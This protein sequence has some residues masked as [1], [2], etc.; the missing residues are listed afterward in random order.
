MDYTHAARRRPAV[1][2]GGH[3]QHALPVEPAGHQGLRRGRRHRGARGRH[4]RHHRCAGPRGHRH[5]GNA[6]GGL[7]A[8]PRRRRPRWP[9]N[10]GGDP[11][12]RSSITARSPW[13][14]PPSCWRPSGEAKLLAG[15]HT[16]LPTMK[17]RLAKPE[18]ASST[19]AG[20]P[21]SRASRRRATAL[22]I[23]AMTT[24]DRGGELGR[25]ALRHRR[26]V[27]GGR[28]HR[29]PARAQP[30]HHRRLGRQQRPVGR[31][32]RRPAGARRHHRHQQARDRGRR[33]LQGPVLDR[34]RRR[35]D[36][37]PHLLPRPG[38]VRLRQVRQPGLALRAGG[39]GG[40][41]DRQRPC[42]S[43]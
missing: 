32:P 18:G 40:G 39:R 22:V 20:W 16:L 23:G 37:H 5:A 6:A 15:G 29:R 7:A 3:D 42:A 34:A 11:C 41:Q 36:H 8:P 31:L 4:Q 9:R 43:R 1:V 25:G 12:T 27:R 21:S 33:L 17:L 28:Q 26:P 38:Q 35:R 2:P 30:R 13:P 24:H 14:T 19:S 10:K